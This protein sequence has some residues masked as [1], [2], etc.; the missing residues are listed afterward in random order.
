MLNKQRFRCRTKCAQMT[1]KLIKWP[2]PLKDGGHFYLFIHIHK[3][4][5]SVMGLKWP[6][7]L[8]VCSKHWMNFR[9]SALFWHVAYY[10]LI[11]ISTVQQSVAQKLLKKVVIF[12]INFVCKAIVLIHLELTKWRHFVHITHIWMHRFD[13]KFHK[14]MSP[15]HCVR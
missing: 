9:C 8:N 5:F 15:D 6:L 2:P 3:F 11:K 4:V 12:I 14:P 7:F 13:R 1:H 10:A